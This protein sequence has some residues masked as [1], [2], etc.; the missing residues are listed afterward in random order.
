MV[1]KQVLSPDVCNFTAP[2][3]VHSHSGG[4][5]IR[6]LSWNTN[7]RSWPPMD[8]ILSRMHPICIPIF[9]L[10]TT[11]VLLPHLRLGVKVVCYVAF[12]VVRHKPGTRSTS[13]I[14]TGWKKVQLDALKNPERIVK[15]FVICMM[16]V[17]DP[18]AYT[19]CLNTINIT[20][21]RQKIACP[22]NY[23]V[24]EIS[25]GNAFWIPACP[26]IL[27]SCDIF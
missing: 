17:M 9:Y 15:A 23:A 19:F 7:V 20:G 12:K 26:E 16:N 8:F 2:W 22:E 6:C 1:T 14:V 3:K 11:L 10:R 24:K 21:Q 18:F 25:C 4:L 5:E 27:Y 13:N